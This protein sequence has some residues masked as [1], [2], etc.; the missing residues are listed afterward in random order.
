[1][2]LMITNDQEIEPEEF[3]REYPPRAV[4]ENVIKNLKKSFG[5]ASF[6]KEVDMICSGSRFKIEN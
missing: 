1:M 4:E 6:N 5:L 3:R 2:S